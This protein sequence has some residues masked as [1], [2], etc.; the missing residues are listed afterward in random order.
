[1]KYLFGN[2]ERQEVKNQ[3]QKKQSVLIGKIPSVIF[4]IIRYS[5][6]PILLLILAA[7]YALLPA[8]QAFLIANENGVCWE[9]KRKLSEDEV[10]TKALKQFLLLYQADFFESNEPNGKG[11]LT[12]LKS[13]RVIKNDYDLKTVVQKLSDTPNSI[14]RIEYSKILDDRLGIDAIENNNIW[15]NDAIINSLSESNYMLVATDVWNNPTNNEI[16]RLSTQKIYQKNENPYTHNQEITM[17]DSINGYG[18]YYFY[19]QIISTSYDTKE[20]RIRFYEKIF[21]VNNCGNS[22]HQTGGKYQAI[23]NNNII[24][25]DKIFKNYRYKYPVSESID[26]L[27]SFLKGVKS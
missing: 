11:V 1:M 13:W 17:T 19:I 8:F 4:S 10:R 16:I 12:Q 14:D 15:L 24:F 27:V 3:I 21:D 18:F 6:I 5:V 9:E 20:K 22:I 25:N 23:Q 26:S 7:V 2:N